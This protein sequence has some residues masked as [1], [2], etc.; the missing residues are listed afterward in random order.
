MYENHN[1]KLNTYLKIF[2][3]SNFQEI[4]PIKCKKTHRALFSSPFAREGLALASLFHG[5]GIVAVDPVHLPWGQTV[6]WPVATVW[7]TAAA[8]TRND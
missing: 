5:S 3:S 8:A 1:F 2:K 4:K 7:S 6:S